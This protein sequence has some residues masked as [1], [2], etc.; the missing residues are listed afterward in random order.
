MILDRASRPFVIYAAAA[1][2]QLTIVTELSAASIQAGKWKDGADVEV[3]AARADGSP[4]GTAAGKIGPG[5]YSTS[6]RFTPAAWPA[7]VSVRLKSGA[8][9]AADDWV[10]VEPPAGTLVGDGVAY[11]SASRVAM[12]PVAAFDFARNERIRVEWPVLTTL[13]RR[14]VRLLDKTGKPLPVDLPLSEDAATHA[15]V[16]EMSL[17]GLG[18][19]DYLI[20]LTAGAGPTTEKHLMAIRIK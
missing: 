17:S 13:D 9:P 19:G 15:I 20:E 7:R 3:V 2:T 8:A 12:R 1:A 6:I 10:K 5:S 18:R 11:R 14:E 16:V 4:I